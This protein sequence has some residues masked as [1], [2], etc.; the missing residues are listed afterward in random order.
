MAE[1][2][3]IEVPAE[4]AGQRLDHFLAGQLDTSRSRVQL[5]VDQGDVVIGSKSPKGSL[6]LRGGES[7]TITG[8]PHPA[9]LKATAEDIPLSIVFEDD[10]LA[11]ID[12]PAGM[13]VH[14]GSGQT[15]DER[16]RGTLVNALLHHFESLSTTGGELRPGIV[17][18]LDKDT[19]GL[20]IVAK[21][22]RT[23]NELA[24]MFSGRDIRKTYIALVH[25]DVARPRGTINAAIARDPLRRTRM[26]TKPVENARSAVSHYEVLRKISTRFGK[27]TLVKVRIETGRTHQIRVHM[28]SIG[29]PVVGDT[30]YGASSQITDQV[31]A[32]A[33]PSRAARRNAAPERLRLERNFLHSAELEFTHP[34]TRKTM[35]LQ[36]PLPAE[37]EAFLAHLEGD[38]ALPAT[39]KD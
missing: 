28:A 20:I 30:L 35:Q 13:M 37:L 23:H 2:R 29:H 26:T 14:A 19:S 6:K 17:H 25:G 24:E 31:V 4:A 5:L 22:D 21:N 27:F 33:A 11:V 10:N 3:T 7:I 38:A 16:S 18:R 36:A 15:E 9:P 8:E 39:S 32:Q 1:I 34:I 12:K